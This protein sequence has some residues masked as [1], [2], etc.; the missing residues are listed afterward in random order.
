MKPFNKILLLVVML[1]VLIGGY[2]LYQW[3][4]T[5]CCE[6]PIPTEFQEMTEETGCS[7]WSSPDGMM[8]GGGC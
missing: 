3:Y 6:P 8:G 5:A 1:L 4:F 7:N 2:F